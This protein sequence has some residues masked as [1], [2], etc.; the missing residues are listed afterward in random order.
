MLVSDENVDLF[1]RVKSPLHRGACALRASVQKATSTSHASTSLWLRPPLELRRRARRRLA[2]ITW[3][4]DPLRPGCLRRG[5][6]DPARA[7]VMI[8]ARGG[9]AL[10]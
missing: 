1:A 7:P 8:D 3:N 10:T 2:G 6:V 4:G 5:R 9:S